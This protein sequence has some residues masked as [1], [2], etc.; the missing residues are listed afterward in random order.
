METIRT[1]LL[2]GGHPRADGTYCEASPELSM[3]IIGVSRA[4]F[5]LLA[6][7]MV[8]AETTHRFSGTEPGISCAPLQGFFRSAGDSRVIYRSRRDTFRNVIN[9]LALNNG[10][11]AAPVILCSTLKLSF[12]R[13][14][15][16]RSGHHENLRSKCISVYI[17]SSLFSIHFFNFL[18][19]NRFLAPRSL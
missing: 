10:R 17:V 16:A 6:I 18:L 5:P 1:I 12:H 7:S 8:T 14:F 13:F 2:F 15:S 11:R 19:K 9:N 4:T 3:F